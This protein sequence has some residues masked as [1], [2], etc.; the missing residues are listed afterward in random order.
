MI[1]ASIDFFEPGLDDVAV[2]L[3]HDEDQIS[4]IAF[5]YS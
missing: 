1:R 5:A 3:L 2:A 4:P